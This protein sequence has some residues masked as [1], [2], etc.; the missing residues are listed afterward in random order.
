[1]RYYLLIFALLFNCFTLHSQTPKKRADSFFGLHYD[2]HAKSTD[3]NIGSTLTAKDVDI[4][5]STIRP[6]FIQVDTKGHQ[7]ISSY[8][9]KIGVVAK[10]I[11]NDPLKL[12]RGETLKYGVALYAHFSGLKD[13]AILKMHPNW[14]LVN[15]NLQ[16]DSETVSMFSPYVYSYFIPQLK[17]IITNY[18]VD[19]LWIDGDCWAIKPD[20]SEPALEAFKNKTGMSLKPLPGKPELTQTKK[21]YQFTRQAYFD[22]LTKYVSALHNFSPNIQIASTWA[23]SGFL[24]G[25]I[26]SGVDFLSGDLFDENAVDQATFESRCIASYGKPWDLMSWSFVPLK[27]RPYSKKSINQLKQEASI[28]LSQGGAYEVYSLQNHDASIPL[29]N[30]T[31]LKQLS[32]FCRALQPYCFKTA[33][34]PQVALLYSVSGTDAELAAPVAYGRKSLTDL[35]KTLNYILNSKY[36]VEVL[37]EQQLL[38]KLNSYPVVVITNWDS[39]S[40]YF[41]TTIIQYVKK[42]GNLLIDGNST[43]S[44][45]NKKLQLRFT[46]NS[47]VNIHTYGKGKI[48]VINTQKSFENDKALNLSK[49]LRVLL[50][51]PLVTS[52]SE[53][54]FHLTASEKDKRILIHIVNMN[55]SYN[56]NRVYDDIKPLKE[57]SI[58][59]NYYKTPLSVKIQPENKALRFNTEGDKTTIFLNQNIAAYSIIEIQ[60]SDK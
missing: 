40:P 37:Q 49:T 55:G 12:F 58:I 20:Y 52:V 10:P 54:N 56:E 19:G 7:G 24:P 3:I 6:D 5:L 25:K 2:F 43:Y 30:I 22:Y 35:K 13:K 14:A 53:E 32:D 33:P 18:G 42:G 21:V 26:D 17:E 48:G 23:Y 27:G 39:L 28:V 60:F 59:L 47:A 51:K 16:P 11:F 4:L 29:D 46:K 31:T 36:S 45:L 50:P 57:M 1:M 9:T 8:P 34:I 38:N 15:S 44:L 41:I